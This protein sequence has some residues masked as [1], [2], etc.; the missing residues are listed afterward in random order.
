MDYQIRSVI[1]EPNLRD[2]SPDAD[3]RVEF[4]VDKDGPFFE[5]FRKADF[6]PT[7]VQLRLSQFARDLKQIRGVS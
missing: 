7:L 4:M 5:R 6:T 2:G 1:E 3:M